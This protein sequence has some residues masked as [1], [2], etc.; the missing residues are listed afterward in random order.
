MN[1]KTQ[2]KRSFPYV[3]VLLVVL[4]ALAAA[5]LLY[6]LINSTGLFGRLNTAA[7]SDNFKIS[8]NQLCVYKYHAA[9]NQ[10]Y[11]AWLYDAYG[12]TKN[13][14][15]S[16]YGS[17]DV[18]MNYMIY[19]YNLSNPHAFDKDA[20]AYAEQYLVYCEGAKAAGVTLTEKDREELDQ[21]M[22]DL[23]AMA[24][25]NGVSLSSYIHSWIGKGVSENDVKKAM[26]IYYLGTK[27]AEIKSDELS[28]GVTDE[29]IDKEVSDNKSSYFST[30]YTYYNL[31]NADLKERA[32]KC[33]TVEELKALIVNYYMEQ[34]FESLYKE[35]ITD[36]NIT[37]EAGKEQTRADVLA[38]VLAWEELSE[39]EPVFTANADDTGDEAETEAETG[40][41]EKGTDKDTP[42][43]YNEAG[44]RIATAISSSA[45]EQF[46]KIYDTGSTS[47]ADP[48]GA[49]ATELQKW[50]F[51]DGRSVGDVN[52]ITKESTGS[53]GKTTTTVTW[54][55]VNEVMVRDEEK[56]KNAYYA[57]LKDDAEGTKDGMTATE[58]Y[59]AFAA[60]PTG[61]KFE[62]IFKSTLHESVS[63]SSLA[64]EIGD[65]LFDEERK[66]GDYTRL[67]AKTTTTDSD[68]KTQTVK[69]DYVILF[70]SENEETWRVD[71][72][73]AVANAKLTAW[74]EEMKETYHVSTDYV[75]ETGTETDSQSVTEPDSESATSAD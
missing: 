43:N 18:Y 54:Y 58:K 71:A 4:L 69:K 52:V 10:L 6:S 16:T 51:G 55:M 68:G 32:E 44:Y 7:R 56:T 3:T 65:W 17:V 46:S 35:L 36:T 64:E 37:D 70:V 1:Q 67:V 75:A 74:I 73:S 47:Y 49:S 12:L 42:A 13:N 59:E 15:A 8:E 26:E 27:Y 19:Q 41:T 30:K 2:A 66:E 62:E 48:A 25:Y 31:V 5:I 45:K 28:D 34:K 14:L 57:E 21:Y 50:L 9:Q 33:K 29:E 11:M 61:A 53:D 60:D 24:E 63:Q 40:D 20:Y 22:K 39:E 23:K 38:T 72:R